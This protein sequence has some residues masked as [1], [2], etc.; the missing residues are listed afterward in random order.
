MLLKK[1]PV[2][3]KSYFR[4]IQQ[5]YPHSKLLN[6][7]DYPPVLKFPFFSVVHYSIQLE[8]DP[9]SFTFLH[10]TS[11]ALNIPIFSGCCLK[12]EIKKSEEKPGLPLVLW[13]RKK[14]NTKPK[15]DGMPKQNIISN[16][17]QTIQ[18]ARVHL[19]YLYLFQG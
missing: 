8:I 2:A 3:F 5:P 18:K 9:G 11:W 16:E 15:A 4:A 7:G 6:T 17:V 12:I 13:R 14:L 1:H 19:M 10:H